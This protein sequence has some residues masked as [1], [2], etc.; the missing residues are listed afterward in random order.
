MKFTQ[1]MAEKASWRKIFN[2]EG[3]EVIDKKNCFF[4]FFV[5]NTFL[6]PACPG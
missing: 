2:H 1:F 4:V 3:H 5:V 6:D